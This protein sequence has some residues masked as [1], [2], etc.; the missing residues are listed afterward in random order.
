MVLDGD[1]KVF[2]IVE[3][4]YDE[5]KVIKLDCVGYV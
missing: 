2:N 1:S 4:V 5:C 3:N